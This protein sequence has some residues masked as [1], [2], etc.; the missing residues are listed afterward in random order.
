MKQLVLAL[1]IM[2]GILSLGA[3]SWLSKDKEPEPPTLKELEKREVSIIEGDAI[4]TSRQAAMENYRAYL[5]A[6]KKSHLRSEAQRRL[7]DLEM[8][9]VEDAHNLALEQD[10]ELTP[11]E[12]ANYRNA[13]HLY[14]DLLKNNPGKKGNDRVLYQ[15]ARAYELSGETEKALKAFDKLVVHDTQSAYYEESQFRRGEMLFSLGKYRQA[16]VAYQS[17]LQTK[18]E[19]TF[20]LKAQY[21]LG[22]AQ[23]KQNKYRAAMDSYIAVL[24][25]MLEDKGIGPEVDDIKDLSRGN[26]ELLNDTL[27]ITSI[28][29]S[30]L[31]GPTTL[32]KLEKSKGQREYIHLLYLRLGRLYLK[33]ER[34]RDA[35]ETLNTFSKYHAEHELAPFLHLQV[36]ETYKKGGFPS[37]TL[38]AKRDFVIRYG[39]DSRYWKKHDEQAH[40]RIVG[41]LKTNL[42]E[43]AQY[44]HALAQKSQKRADYREAANW[45]QRY[46]NS[47]PQ[48]PKAP[49]IRF[50][51]AESLYDSKQYLAAA[52]QY[53]Q[54]AYDY[55]KHKQSAEAG[56]AS[57]LAYQAHE[58]S[59]SAR[60]RKKFHPRVTNS[61]IRFASE[62]PGDKRMPKVLARAAEDLFKEKK[63]GQAISAADLLIKRQPTI[64]RKLMRIAWTVK[65]HSQF[66][67]K[68]YL[69]AESSYR[70]LLALLPARDKARAELTD[71]LAASIYKQGEQAR[72][73]NDH[74]TAAA[75]F[76]RVGRE[77]PG[78]KLRPTAEYDA[79][80]SLISVEKWSQAI[81]VLQNFRKAYP[82][83]K[84]AA[85]VTSKL[86]VAY[87][88]V[89]QP[90]SAASEFSRIAAKSKNPAIR[91]E[92]LEQ[93]ADLYRKSGSKNKAIA[94]Y[95]QYIKKYPR[96]LE[97][98]VEMRKT[99]MD[100]YRELRM[101]DKALYW[102][103]QI[104]RADAKG[105]AAR[106]KRTRFLAA[107]ATLELAGPVNKSFRK[108]RLTIPLKKSLRKKR[109]AMKKALKAYEKAAAY[110]FSDIATN[111]TWHIA[112]IYLRF[113][114]DLMKSQ[115]PRGMKGDT[116][117][118]YDLLLEEQAFPFEEKSIDFHLINIKRTTE[119]VYDAWVRKSYDSLKKLVPA[120]YD[121]PER[122]EDYVN[123]IR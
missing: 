62:F 77:V 87:L 110:G 7:A 36:I 37:Q 23:F 90:K 66:E 4:N 33:Q 32:V 86:A 72:A 100:L 11:A 6:T 8:E 41:Y 53:E 68:T 105:R 48:D 16:E 82:N 119:G 89:N 109:R 50:L 92:A 22:W 58:K 115:R 65:A 107:E 116:L 95:K 14:E 44:Y 20:Q 84:L 71:R 111:A 103:K 91:R 63:Y 113:S 117:E 1:F 57:L 81:T 28:T 2:P 101:N 15:L 51:L 94:A 42:T 80:A 5:A 40:E 45:Y 76:L 121:R 30:Y 9:R 106:T 83:H 88:K 61:A 39:T 74:E 93:S 69:D 78:S 34:I 75:H 18:H 19:S 123:A 70:Q 25:T 49:S 98:T 29:L 73:A 10:R 99:I 27:R 24:D 112:N 122:L 118:E 56:Y 104:I 54:T 31:D 12:Q 35:A 26:K 79:A 67:L 108:I 55:P 17:V 85:D 21:K 3:C 96:P 47:F 13:I 43:L 60:A 52:D 59:L 114:Q 102:Q 97:K 64:D 120:R 38:R 46:L